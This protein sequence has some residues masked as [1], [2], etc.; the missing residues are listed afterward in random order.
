MGVC[1]LWCVTDRTTPEIARQFGAKVFHFP[2]VN[3]FSAARNESLRLATGE[4]L[5]WM[6]ADDVIDERNGEGLRNLAYSQITAISPLWI[7][8]NYSATIRG[9]GSSIGFTSKY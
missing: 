6:D 4:W 9:F 8:S 3:S 2:W 1:V 7:M 5:F